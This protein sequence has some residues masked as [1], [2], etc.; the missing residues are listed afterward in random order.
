[1]NIELL[2]ETGYFFGRLLGLLL[3]LHLGLST[4]GPCLLCT[5]DADAAVSVDRC[6]VSHRHSSQ[7]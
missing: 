2:C 4:S 3:G 1:M 7:R 5:V 6:A